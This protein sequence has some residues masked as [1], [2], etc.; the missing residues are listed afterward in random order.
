MNSAMDRGTLAAIERGVVEG[1]RGSVAELRKQAQDQDSTV[2]A[3]M[4]RVADQVEAKLNEGGLLL[5]FVPDKRVQELQREC[6][7]YHLA[8]EFSR[9][10]C[11]SLQRQLKA[12]KA[13]LARAREEIAQM[14]STGMKAHGKISEGLSELVRLS[15]DDGCAQ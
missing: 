6:S 8:Q 7:R 12:A 9:V 10:Q 5:S 13:D 2:S 4:L 1:L 3:S 14:R 15:G 11:E